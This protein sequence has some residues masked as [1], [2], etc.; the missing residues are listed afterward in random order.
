[1]NPRYEA[2][3]NYGMLFVAG[4]LAGMGITTLIFVVA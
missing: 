3:M 2:M 1:M 4:V